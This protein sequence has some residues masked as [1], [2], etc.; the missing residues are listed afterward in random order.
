MLTSEGRVSRKVLLDG[1]VNR[2][3]RGGDALDL[4]FF[5]RLHEVVEPTYAEVESRA[6]DY[7]RL[8]PAAPGPVAELS[9]KHLRRLDRLDPADVTEAL[10][11]LLFR[12]EGGLVRTGLTWLD[13]AVRQAPERADEFV[14]A[15][16][17]ALGHEAYAV[18]EKAVRLVVKHARHLTPLGAETLRAVLTTL[19]PDLGGKLAAAVGGEAELQEEPET[20]VPGN[21][22]SRSRGAVS[23]PAR[24]GRRVRDQ[25][26]GRHLAG[27]ESWLAG[28]VRFAAED[29]EALR[30]ALS[31]VSPRATGFYRYED[32]YS[33]QEWF[34]ATA[35]ELVSPG[36]DPGTPSRLAEDEETRA[37]DPGVRVSGPGR[38]SRT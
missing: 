30:A 7:L 28:F 12:A 17:T 2:F 4:R 21:S 9:L 1:C 22:P 24:H 35:A 8:L 5:T 37:P 10:E 36:A 18:Q 27:G 32:W 20:F 33:P 34:T 31:D 29:R 14:P 3:L 19:P 11:G 6:R 16:V 23:P 15:L 25:A 13:Q 26:V 38:E